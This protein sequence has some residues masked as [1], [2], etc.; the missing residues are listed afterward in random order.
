MEDALFYLGVQSIHVGIKPRFIFNMMGM[1]Q[2]NGWS[3]S[4]LERVAL[5]IK[6]G[7][8]SYGNTLATE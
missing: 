6:I 4:L 7:I 5:F 1:M 8:I 2:K 3:S